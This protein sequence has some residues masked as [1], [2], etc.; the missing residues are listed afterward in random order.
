[1]HCAAAKQD[2]PFK[3]NRMMRADIMARH[4]RGAK[5]SRDD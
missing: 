4:V 2:Q 1:M 5:L 3:S